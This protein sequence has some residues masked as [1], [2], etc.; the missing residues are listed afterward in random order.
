VVAR[1]T[2]AINRRRTAGARALVAPLDARFD[3]PVAMEL[4][5]LLPDGFPGEA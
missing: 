1:F 3:P 4:Q 5:Q 2:D